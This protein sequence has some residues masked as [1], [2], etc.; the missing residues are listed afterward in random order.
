MTDIRRVTFL[1]SV[2]FFFNL[3]TLRVNPRVPLS[4]TPSRQSATRTNTHRLPRPGL[5]QDGAAAPLR[6]GRKR[7][8]KPRSRCRAACVPE[9]SDGAP[10]HRGRFLSVPHAAGCSGCPGGY[11]GCGRV[12]SLTPGM[13]REGRAG[14]G[15]GVSGRTSSSWEVSCA[16]GAR[17]PGGGG[18][19]AFIARESA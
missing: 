15:G 16:F 11:A 8:R 13:L 17:A 5:P 18:Q 10:E 3:A 2:F 19:T 14:E 12:V 4:P 6:V 7:R 1:I 9:G